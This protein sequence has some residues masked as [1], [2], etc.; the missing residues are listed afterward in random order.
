MD[1]EEMNQRAFHKEERPETLSPVDDL[2]YFTLQMLYL[3]HQNKLYSRAQ[4][5]EIKQNLAEEYSEYK[6]RELEW[7]R[8][9]TVMAMLRQHENPDVRNVVAEID[10]INWD[11]V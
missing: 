1:F 10:K 9:Q 8:C 5:V 11:N 7:Q 3:L 2:F 6:K 4:C